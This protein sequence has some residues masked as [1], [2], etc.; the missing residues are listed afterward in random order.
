MLITGD[1]RALGEE[2]HCIIVFC[3]QVP[4]GSNVRGEWVTSVRHPGDTDYWAGSKA[5]RADHF[6]VAGV[7]S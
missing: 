4:E 2:L 5:V 7:C 1:H 6:V 3:D